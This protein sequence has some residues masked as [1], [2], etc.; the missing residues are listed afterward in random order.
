M[1]SF[2]NVIIS[3]SNRPIWQIPLAAICF[4]AAFGFLTYEAGLWLTGHGPLRINIGHFKLAVYFSALGVGLTYKKRI[5]IDIKSSRFRPT[6]EVGPLKFGS[7]I[8]IKDYDCVSVFHRLLRN[9]NS[10]YEVNLWYDKNKHF[11]LYQKSDLMEA[12]LIGYK[13]SEELDI[14]L[15]DATTP[16]EFKWVEKEDWKSQMK[17]A[18]R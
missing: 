7:W 12:F 17:A 15:Y 14:G 2:E 10:I 8:T 4:T 11:E 18:N 16:N 1:M 13:L 9:G 6:F 3:E 5:Y